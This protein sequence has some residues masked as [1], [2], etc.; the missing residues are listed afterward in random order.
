MTF[1]RGELSKK[2]NITSET[3]RYYENLGII[4]PPERSEN[5]YR[6]YSYDTLN[7]LLFVKHAK[8]C[9]FTLKEIKDLLLLIDSNSINKDIIKAIIDNKSKDLDE[10]IKNLTTMKSVLDEALDN[11][12]KVDC[13]FIN[14][15]F[16]NL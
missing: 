11:A 3:L 6:Q 10:K 12:K 16:K 13:T 2:T 5:K 8:L 7:R 15:I 4:P 1:T 9:G 14:S